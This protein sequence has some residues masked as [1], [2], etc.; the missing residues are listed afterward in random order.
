MEVVLISTLKSLMHSE[1]VSC[2]HLFL[3]YRL[4][5]SPLSLS[6]GLSIK[7][8]SSATIVFERIKSKQTAEEY[9]T[10]QSASTQD[11]IS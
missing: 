5:L 2:S 11:T 8:I 1:C 6:V 9:R 4:N 7:S 10:N 3:F